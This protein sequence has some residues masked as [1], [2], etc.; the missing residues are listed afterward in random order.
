M[1]IKFNEREKIWCEK[2]RPM[3][4]D[5]CILPKGIREAFKG[6]V[7]KG[8]MPS[9]ILAGS[10]G[11]GKTTA[12][13]AL[14]RELGYDYIL[15]NASND[16]NIDVLRGTITQFASS[17][18]L[19]SD[20][21]VVILDEADY[22]NANTLQPALRG[23][24]EEFSKTT[25]FIF[26]CNYPQRIIPA[27]HSRCSVFTYDIPKTERQ[28]IA[29][30]FMKRVFAILENEGIEY[31]KPTIAGLIKKHFPDYRRVLNELQRYASINGKVD[32]DILV[33][34]KAYNIAE[35][36]GYL[37]DKDFKSM[38]KWA[39]ENIADKDVNAVF[40]EL[41]DNL[42]E[43]VE[44]VAIP[45]IILIMAQYSYQGVTCPDPEINFVAFCTE[46]MSNSFEWK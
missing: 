40:R 31:D 13:K 46:L 44:P 43:Y 37:K 30:A 41:Y 25:R 17:A 2:Y 15:I 11:T 26:T 39:V 19:M 35:L 28:E 16:R 1:S 33:S 24:I 22:A 9:I 45:Q 20:V 3:T 23:A 21:K 12:A 29:L 27:L 32:A 10:A 38:R 4:I 34:T 6:F 8:D 14:C 18:S 36:V 42:Y 7:E 5:E